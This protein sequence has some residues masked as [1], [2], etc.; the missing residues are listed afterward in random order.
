M[1]EMI[2]LEAAERVVGAMLKIAAEDTARIVAL[3]AEISELQRQVM[4]NANAWCAPPDWK[5]QAR[6]VQ[7]LLDLC[8]EHEQGGRDVKLGSHEMFI[9]IDE[10]R[11]RL[12]P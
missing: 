10:I 8:D 4:G 1:T 2:H 3:E 9:C 12:K 11:E 7:S 5:A 6:R